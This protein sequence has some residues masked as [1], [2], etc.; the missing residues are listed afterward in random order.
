MDQRNLRPWMISLCMACLVVASCGTAPEMP[1]LGTEVP[2]STPLPPTA[3]AAQVEQFKA[4]VE[5]LANADVFSGAVL[6]AKDG[7]PIFK[8]AYGL[9]N[10]RANIPNR[11]DTKFNL[12]SMNKMFTAVAIAQLAQGGKL[13]FHDLVGT[14]L[15]DYPNKQVAQ[16]VTIHHLLTHTSGMGD[17]LRSMGP[18]KDKLRSVADYFPLFVDAPLAFKPGSQYR[19]SNTGYIV[20][21]AIIEQVSGQS[22]FDYVRERIYSL[23]GMDNT[24]AYE[25]GQDVPNLAIGYTGTTHIV[26][27]TPRLPIKGGP[28]GGGYSTVEDLLK[29]DIALRTHTLLSPALTQLMLTGKVASGPNFKYAYGFRDLQVNGTRIVGHNGGF[30]GIGARFDMY[31]DLGYTVVVLSNYDPGTADDVANRFGEIITRK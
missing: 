22:Y 29:F 18:A 25:R 11:V 15:R 6:V 17:Y 12:G 31:L 23:A 21:G 4:I 9:A 30:A 24:D 14:H 1:A 19:Y 27:N 13:A 20:L 7:V 2:P 3:P 28:A 16:T 10:K 5:K 26:E 8:Q